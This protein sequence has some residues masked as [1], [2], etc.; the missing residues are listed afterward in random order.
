MTALGFDD[1]DFSVSLV[2]LYGT[3]LEGEQRVVATHADVLA[4]VVA[5]AALANDDVASD[6]FFATEL[7]D[8]EALGVAI[9]SVLTGSLSF[10]VSHFE[11]EL[12][13]LLCSDGV[14]LDDRELLAVAASS[15]RALFASLLE[16]QDLTAASVFENCSADLSAVNERIA[17]LE[18][19]AFA[20]S[21]DFVDFQL[22]ARFRVW[23]AIKDEDVAFLYSVLLAVCL[24]RSF[25]V[26]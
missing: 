3:V 5:C 2:E 23:I 25:H 12:K 9:A 17:E 18:S 26:K 22:G 19:I 24:D 1:G 11:S 13:W 16:Y 6:D 4:G 10:F 21:Q 8:A 14:D 15:L 20:D 7:L